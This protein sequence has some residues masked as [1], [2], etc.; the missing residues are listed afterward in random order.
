[1]LPTYG[2]VVC[3]KSKSDKGTI[4]WFL[5]TSFLFW[6]QK[7]EIELVLL[8]HAFIFSDVKLMLVF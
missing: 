5:E 8:L 2:A 3:L 6:M 4:D 1:M 7:M